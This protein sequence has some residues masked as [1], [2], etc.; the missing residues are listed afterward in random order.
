MGILR[1]GLRKLA[2][3]PPVLTVVV[4]VY[5]VEDYLREALDSVLT[6][7][8]VDVEVVAVDDGSTDS[9]LEI[10]R[11]YEARD[12][13]VRAFTQANAGQGIARNVGVGHAR[14][15]FLTFM[16]SD[17]TIPADAYEHMVSTLRAS[18]SD[19]CVGAVRRF[20]GKQFLGASWGRTVHQADRIGTTLEQFPAAMQDILAC[21]RVFR[22][23][24]WRDRVG[25]FRGGI[26]YEDHVPML[27]AYVRAS[28]FDVLAKVTYNWRIRAGSTGQSKASLQNLLDRIEV[29]VEAHE[30]LKAEATDFVYDVWVA[31]CLEVDFGPFIA[32]AVEAEV[33]YRDALAETYRLFN[34]RASERTWDLVRAA[35]KV[36][37]HLVAAGRWDDVEAA[38]QWFTAVQQVPPT[39]V[40]DGRLTAVLPDVG[41]ARDLPEHVLRL[42]SLESHFEGAVQHLAPGSDAVELTGWMRHRGLDVVGARPEMALSLRADGA[43][44]LELAV[45][46][47]VFPAANL[48]AQLPYSGC[49]NAGFRVRVPLAAL[50][51]GR[52]WTLH[53]T[54]VGSGITSSGTFHYPVPGSSA[55]KP[56]VRGVEAFW[57]PA[58]GF[59]L[60]TGTAKPAPRP[61]GPLLTGL[62]LTDDEIAVR[63]AGADASDVALGGLTLLGVAD[64][65]AR[66][67]TRLDGRPAPSGVLELTVG[68]V[69][70][71]AGE[72]FRGTLPVRLLASTHRLDATLGKRLPVRIALAAPLAD[73][74]LGRYHQARLQAAYQRSTA[75]VR[76]AVLLAHPEIDGYLAEHRPE[77]ERIWAV[78][79]LAVPVPAGAR[80]VLLGS[81]SWYDAVATSRY[82]VSSSD[83]GGW[84]R[85]RPEQAYLRTVAGDP[86]EPIGLERWRDAGQTPLQVRDALAR[87]HREWDL[88]V[89]PDAATEARYREQF[90][91]D[92]DVLVADDAARIVA[93]LLER[94]HSRNS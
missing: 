26:A 60:R 89:V 47:E 87:V 27:A 84:F 70:V 34:S 69:A 16:D 32:Q 63:L 94:R 2:G 59:S 78:P 56:K 42:S 17:D 44:P 51:P 18:G 81:A 85:R 66:F 61:D 10:L 37:G 86:S 75:P 83:L 54:I 46:H 77:L 7:T 64:G 24:F 5:N 49:A 43:E 6:Q 88:L 23:A 25:D 53:G 4:P 55:E 82:L 9:C 15:E 68:G 80:T 20:R 19:F 11:E 3:R 1:R 62:A 38:S 90:A 76:D 73:D 91:Y 74:E 22:T 12:P 30:L 48:W 79:D 72:E 36:R 21:N 33:A 29:K 14:G 13:R 35:S 45:E 65:E 28:T 52:T 92:G 58:R 41:W 8:L 39:V 93:A 57:D 40:V 71:R 67:S 50:T 31:R